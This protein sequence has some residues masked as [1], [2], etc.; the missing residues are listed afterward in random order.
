MFSTKPLDYTLMFSRTNGTSLHRLYSVRK[1]AWLFVS[2]VFLFIA[3][4]AHSEIK[5]TPM[6]P[7]SHPDFKFIRE[8]GGIQEYELLSNGLKV[9][10]KEDRSS[11][12]VTVMVTYLV[13][14]RHESDG[15]RGSAHLL[16]HMMFKGTERYQ[17]QKGTAIPAVLQRVGAHMNASTWTDGTNYYET[18][19]ADQLDLALDIESARMRGSLFRQEDLSS[20]MHV[21]HSELEKIENSPFAMLD[22]ALWQ[23]AFTKHPYHYPVIGWRKDIEET[24]AAALHRF[25]DTYYW[26]NNAVLAVIGSYDSAEIL[27]KIAGYFGSIGRSPSPVPVMGLS[28]PIQTAERHTEIRREDRVESVIIAHKIPGLTH[29]DTAALDVLGLIL[30]SGKNSR[31]YRE[32]V[33]RGLAVDVRSDPSK[34][35]DPGLFVSQAILSPGV[36]H[37]EIREKILSIYKKIRQ[38]GVTAE[39][40]ANAKT[41]LETH[42]LF[43][44]DGSYHVAQELSGLIAAGD[45]SLYATY[46]DNVRAL[47]PETI[48]RAAE[49]YLNEARMTTADLISKNPSNREETQRL[50]E[51]VMMSTRTISEDQLLQES[52]ELSRQTPH[53]RKEDGFFNKKISERVTSANVHGIRVLTI[54]TPVEKVVTITG[55]IEGAGQAYSAN[56]VL[57]E[58][59]VNLLDEGTKRRDKFEIARLLESRGAQIGFQIGHKRA[60]FKARCLAKDVKLVMELISEQLRYPLF[61]A[62]EFEKQKQRL[63]VDIV[64]AMSSTSD[65]AESALS[66]LIY[67]E[68]HSY[69]E[70][71]FESQLDALKKLTRDEVVRFHETRY[72]PK[73][74]II[75]AAG[76]IES[77]HFEEVVEKTM[78]GWPVNKIPVLSQPAPL[79]LE[80]PHKLILPIPD[81][82]KFDVV[83]GHAMPVVYGD[84]LYYPLFLANF[85]LGGDFSSRL[86]SK[87]RDEYGLT[88]S[89]YSELSGIDRTT[90][91]HWQVSLILNPKVL[92]RGIEAALQEINALKDHL[93]P[94]AEVEENKT[95]LKG[96]YQVSLS[97]TEGIALRLLANEEMNLPLSHLDNYPQVIDAV[98]TEQ[99]HQAIAKFFQPEKIQIAIAGP[100]NESA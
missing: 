96:M 23:A 93:P 73:N 85:I 89:I 8:A 5:E 70:P 48:Q 75:V 82:S 47:T 28:E 45:W 91:G 43:S 32:L 4:C 50:D 98:T 14:S 80:E 64:H 38:D 72:S 46:L 39:E 29:P 83:L 97:T 30:T 31:L 94:E 59:V 35:R 10:L 41:Q 81:K 84:P 62:A 61:D 52:D 18:L 34:T 60:G 69:Y 25:Y 11:P 77:G 19:P 33:N 76:D 16:E 24:D 71:P 100:D 44:R 12:V 57:P 65:Q 27:S 90:Q 1:G 63:E 74:M 13:G 79:T 66:R 92:D 53:G 2:S 3:G 95:T 21:V 15:H 40:V 87:V 6:S 26:P 9:L 51:A 7:I 54:K 78:R 55:S 49:T 58:M 17:K 42:I 22:Q 88:Y 56:P 37:D 36:P 99:L 67:P 20:E 68:G 86:S